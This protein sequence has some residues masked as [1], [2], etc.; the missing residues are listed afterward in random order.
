MTQPHTQRRRLRLL[1]VL[2]LVAAATA[3]ALAQSGD[4]VGIVFGSIAEE[5]TN[6]D[7]RLFKADPRLLENQTITEFMSSHTGPADQAAAMA[8]DRI[9]GEARLE[10]AVKGVQIDRHAGLRTAEVVSATPGGAFLSGP[11]GDRA[12]TLRAFLRAN[13]DAYGVTS[14]QVAELEL[15]ADYMNP[16]G[17]MGWAEF[18]QKVNGVPVFQGAIR[19]G[20]TAK[21]ELVRT[22]GVLVTGMDARAVSASVSVSA[23]QAIALAAASVGWQVTEQALVQRS[24]SDDGRT[25]IFA[26]AT[27]ADDAKAW[28]V[29]FPLAPGNLRLAW[30]TE[31]WGSPDAFLT[32]IDA[33]TGTLLFRKNL[34]SY[35]TQAASYTVYPSDSPAP[36]SPTPALPGADFQAPTVSRT[37][38]TL[39][40]NEAP[41]TFNNLG[42]MTDGVNAGNG[43]TDGNNVEAGIDR[44]GVNGVDAV[45]GGTA[46]SFNFAYTP[47][48]TDPLTPAH[49]QGDITN[50]FYWV[51][52]FH[53]YTY[54]LGF[55]E[56]ARNFQHENFGRGGVQ[57]DRIS[58]EGQDSSGTNNANFSSG[59]DGSRGRMQMFLWTG[60]TPDRSGDLDQ[61]IIFHELAHGLSNRLHA[62]SSGLSTNMADGMGEGWSDFYARSLLSTDGENPNGLYTIGGWATHLAAAG[63]TD[64]YYSGIR[65]F[66]YAPRSVV[67]SN[68]RPHSPL[69][70]ADIDATQADLTDG[71]FPRG[72]FG[73]A[74]VDQVHNIGEVWAG[75]LWEVRARFITRLGFAGNQRL[76]QFVTDGMK[77]DPTGP[78][79][80]QARDAILAAAMA[81]GGTSADIADI[82]AGFAAR[83]MG[84]MAAITNVGTGM[85]NTRVVESFLTPVDP[86]PTFSINDVSAR[87]GDAGTTNFGFT[88]TLANPGSSEAR[89]SFATAAGT[90]ALPPTAAFTAATATALPAAATTTGPASPYPVTLGI[91]GLSGSIT[92]VGVRLNDVTHTFPADLDFLLVGPGGQRAMILSDA[93]G[94]GDISLADITLE[95]GAPAPPAALSSGSYAPTDAEPGD[96]MA[97]PAPAGPYASPLSIFNGTSPNG[98]WSLFVMDDAGAD[99]GSMAGFTLFISTTASPADLQFSAGQLVFPPGTT[100]LPVN[101]SV[102]G[103]TLGEANETFFVNLS[104]PTQ[105]VIGDGQ[106]VGVILNDDAG[107]P[108]QPPF[109]LRVDSVVGS[110]VTLRWDTI[111]FG[112]Q[113]SQFILEGGIAP[114]EVL[115]S[116]PTYS[117]STIFTFLAPNGS[118]RIRMHGVLGAEKTPASNEVRLHVNAPVAPSAPSG[119]LALVNGNGLALAW[120]NTFGGGAP[121]DLV[122]DVSGAAVLSMPLGLTESFSFAGVPPG[123]YT[124]SL[125]AINAAGASPSSNPVTLAFPGACSGVP[126]APTNLL[127]Y[128]VGN[129]VFVVWDP[130]AAGPAPTNYVLNV[131][132]T[133]SGSF[134]TA[135][136]SMSGTV[137]S[138][139]YSLSVV[140]TN[141]CGV[142]AP[143]P[144]TVV[145][146]P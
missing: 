84:V 43:H 104:G 63:Y 138:G 73:S 98:V 60:P 117:A 58:A 10:A 86:S 64:N 106:G 130:P 28:Q 101:I 146:V 134:G 52:R 54:L 111:P 96:T 29:Y 55:T 21:G 30:A 145:V 72:P 105:A 120:K 50:M 79:M 123:T 37:T 108:L 124:L 135:I 116:I 32:V 26:R 51:N 71:A 9:G 69:T 97:A 90:A 38:F 70:F 7:I 112:P 88:V 18:E 143:T 12:S 33:E 109:N 95:D 144:A 4:R 49:Q 46:R 81:G 110:T 99:V 113:A 27:M 78:T 132:G 42:W 24:A 129:T 80:L 141:P 48:V 142:G 137:G 136:R 121:T 6:F 119:L 67:G 83:G 45:V 107:G 65:R 127:G 36:S 39:I 66:P 5:H 133:L 3:S 75:M 35:Q 23:G 85:N 1:P 92:R 47:G 2:A 91:A 115:A 16:A 44:D 122:L 126:Q 59:T 17:N 61:D 15:V 103:D 89:V 56:Q 53:D 11:S 114:G 34:T 82:W 20:F 77:L 139:S 100:S 125:R 76:L 102:T 22:T 57:N 93:G 31:I 118:F 8:A 140:A 41:Y 68:G 40:G 13:A 19:G 25:R 94:D 87:E 14:A 128:R 131:S 74:T 62:N